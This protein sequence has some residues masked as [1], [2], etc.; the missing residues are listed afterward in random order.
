MKSN[1]FLERNKNNIKALSNYL[2]KMPQFCYEF[3]VGIENY[4]TPLTR[5]NYASDLRIFF[6]YISKFK[7]GKDASKITLDDLNQLKLLDIEKFLSYLSYYT[8][9][10]KSYTN[11]EKGKGR[12]LATLRTLFKYFYNKDYLKENIASKIKTPKQ[13][14]K[15]IIRLEVDEVANILNE[16]ENPQFMSKTQ[17]S[18]NKHTKIRD[19]AILTVFLGTGIR[20]SECV[21]LNVEDIDFRN[22]AFKVTRK[23]G[24]QVVLYFSSEVRQAL[25]DYLKERDSKFNSDSNALFLSLQNKRITPRAVQNLV[26]KYAQLITPLKKISPH[27]LRSTYGTNLY[28]ETQDIYVVADVLGHKDVNTTKKHYAAISED[29]RRKAADKVKLR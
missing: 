29:I 21:G 10:E 1:Y 8:Y 23:G 4:T 5:L 2:E 3:F 25:I 19:V 12:K 11:N 15:P 18:Y 20:I 14:Q 17:I 22:N 24:S 9:E 27:K 16:A 7:F 6:D 26:K 28:R 13:Y